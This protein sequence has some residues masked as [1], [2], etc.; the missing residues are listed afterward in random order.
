MV[1]SAPS[2]LPLTAAFRRCGLPAREIWFRYL[3]LGGNGDEVSVE[4]QLYGFLE[5]P[6]GEFN[7][8]AHTLNEELDEL[9]VPERMPPVPFLPV[10]EGHPS[11]R[12]HR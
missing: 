8:L 7:V 6:P 10:E 2:E 4:A 12:G 1:E 3:A 9:P 11:H 5:L